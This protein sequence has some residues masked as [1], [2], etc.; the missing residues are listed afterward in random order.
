MLGITLTFALLAAPPVTA[1]QE[2]PPGMVFIKGGKTKIGSDVKDVEPMVLAN[3]GLRNALASE[4][5]QITVDVDDFWLMPTEVTNEQYAQFVRATGAKPPWYWGRKED[6]DAAR[7]AFFEEDNRLRKEA[8]DRGERRERGKFDQESWWAK[9]WEGLDWE[10]PQERLDQPVVY[11]THSD[12]EDYAKWAGLRLM[13]EFEYQRA[14]RGTGDSM[15]PWGDDWDDREF[16]LSLHA[17][18]DSTASVGSFPKGATDKGIYDLSGNVWEWTSSPFKAYKGYKKLV[19]KVGKGKNAEKIEGLA[20]FD[21]NMRVAVSG[22]Y[23]QDR[24]GVR[25]TTRRGTTRTQS[26]DALGFRCAATASVGADRAAAL[27]EDEVRFEHLPADIE[28]A[29]K[30]VILKQRWRTTSTTNSTPGYAVLEGHDYALFC[31]VAKLPFNNPATMTKESAGAPVPLGFLSITT[32]LAQ[33]ELD[34]GTYMIYWRGAGKLPRPEKKEDEGKAGILLG[35]SQED[36]P[37]WDTPGFSADDDCFF[38]YSVYGEPQAAFKAKALQ[39]GRLKSFGEVKVEPFV[40]PD[41]LP[42]NAPPP[43]PMDTVLFDLKIPGKSKSKG[44][45]LELPVKVAPN[46]VDDSWK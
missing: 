1:P 15:Y 9:S 14:A 30:N 13:T 33:P 7:Q 46:V 25:V 28:F 8:L 31:P 4:T 39:S 32:P 26:T 22:S 38:F 19:I 44:F 6:V 29:P 21:P 42:K 45:E 12:A 20:G 2:G 11:V 35:G 23:K 16:C 37:F 43:V 5:P 18:R 17:G 3:R 36:T 41:K 40:M 27:L 24:I 34:A 10:V